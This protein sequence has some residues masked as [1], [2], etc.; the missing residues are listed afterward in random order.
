MVTPRFVSGWGIITNQPQE[1][2]RRPRL[3]RGNQ[4]GV[5]LRLLGVQR[6][7]SREG[8]AGGG[9]WGGSEVKMEAGALGADEF[10]Q[11]ELIPVEEKMIKDDPNI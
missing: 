3:P 11:D 7:R 9:G 10:T 2:E 6:C 4:G 8:R 1:R 5:V